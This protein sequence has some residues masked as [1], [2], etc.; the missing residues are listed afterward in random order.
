MFF[1]KKKRKKNI[2]SVKGGASS[3]ALFIAMSLSLGCDGPRSTPVHGAS[4]HPPGTESGV[5]G[6]VR[7]WRR[8]GDMVRFAVRC[9]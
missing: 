3:P 6:H 5:H 9:R 1:R 2:N 7:A 8:C 4:E